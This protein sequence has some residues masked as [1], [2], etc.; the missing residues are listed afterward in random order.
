MVRINR[1]HTGTGDGG[2]NKPSPFSTIQKFARRNPAG[3]LVGYDLGK[4]IFSKIMNLMSFHS[5]SFG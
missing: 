2:K 3:A 1:V 5:M 4:G